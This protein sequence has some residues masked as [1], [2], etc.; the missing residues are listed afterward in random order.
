MDISKFFL[1]IPEDAR[2]SG[3]KD[4]YDAAVQ[5]AEATGNHSK[6]ECDVS[7]AMASEIAIKDLYEVLERHHNAGVRN[8]ELFLACTFAALQWSGAAEVPRPVG[9]AIAALVLRAGAGIAIERFLPAIRK[10]K[11]DGKEK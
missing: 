1:D 3:I 10:S 4:A 9:E 11:G 2:R 7:V 5:S 8:S 6:E